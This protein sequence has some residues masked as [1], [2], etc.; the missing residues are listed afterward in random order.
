MTAS[1]PQH[2]DHYSAGTDGKRCSVDQDRVVF[3]V[4]NINPDAYF[5]HGDVQIPILEGSLVHFMGGIPHNTIV[6]S[7]SVQLLGP[8]DAKGFTGVGDATYTCQC[9]GKCLAIDPTQPTYDLQYYICVD[10]P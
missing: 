9:Q 8:F 6:N 10:C 5:V 4:L 2:I 1:L 7:G 3:V